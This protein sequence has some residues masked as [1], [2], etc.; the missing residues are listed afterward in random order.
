MDLTAT[1]PDC[2]PAGD[3]GA[4]VRPPAAI[5]RRAAA[6]A[7][8]AAVVFF[9]LWALSVLQVLWFVGPLSES[10]APEPWGRA[11]VATAI[12]VGL[13][14][15]Y[16]IVYVTWN[17]GQTPGKERFKV[18]VVRHADQSGVGFRRATVRA[19]LPVLAWLV[20]PLWLAAALLLTTGSS[21]PFGRRRAAWHDL[22]SGTVAIHY[23]RA[24]EEEDQAE[25]SPAGG[26]RQQGGVRREIHGRHR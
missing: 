25:E 19:L 7:A 12:F 22:L 8:D 23:D 17:Q 4:H 1:V 13:L 3:P 5:W 20:S 11:F 26:R 21:V 18:R 24:A 15:I 16:E 10:V 6:R 14:L 9:V 2:T